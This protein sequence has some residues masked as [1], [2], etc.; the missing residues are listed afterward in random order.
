MGTITIPRQHIPCILA[1]TR[2]EVAR[3][4]SATPHVRT[5]S[6][7]EEMD[8]DLAEV[9]QAIETSFEI[10]FDAREITGD[11]RVS[12]LLAALGNKEIVTPHRDVCLTATTF[13]RMR[14]AARLITRDPRIRPRSVIQIRNRR[15]WR[16]FADSAG[17]FR[18]PELEFGPGASATILLGSLM[19][20]SA[21]AYA[22]YPLMNS[23][24]LARIG[25]GAFSCFALILSATAIA[26]LME[27]FASKLP[28]SIPT[29]GDLART[30][31]AMNYAKLARELPSGPGDTATKAKRLVDVHEA[32]FLLLGDV[33]GIEPE[34][35]RNNRDV[36]IL[37]L[38]E[39][40]EGLRGGISLAR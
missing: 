35:V 16:A 4:S 34:F 33:T 13:W 30:M 1:E 7:M 12:E 5:L 11:T 39:G 10:Q 23:T 40:S 6:T 24:W 18:V 19:L 37:D 26:R 2:A 14:H 15:T 29:A 38:I 20:T 21:A 9:V 17:S 22:L 31:A 32:V 27:P 25:C 36:R 8:P 28:D 3:V